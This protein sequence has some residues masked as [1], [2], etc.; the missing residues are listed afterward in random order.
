M[1]GYLASMAVFAGLSAMMALG[2]NLVWGL[3]GMVNLGLVGFYAI[4]A[5]TTALLCLKLGWPPL[6]GVLAAA[7]L[8]AP[9]AASWRWSRRG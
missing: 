6:A 2:L 5:Y 3:A 7:V 8:S 1:E 9:S 4:G